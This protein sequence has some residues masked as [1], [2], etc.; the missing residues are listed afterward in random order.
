M[1]VKPGL[2]EKQQRRQQQSPVNTSEGKVQTQNRK[3]SFERREFGL[4]SLDDMRGEDII[5]D[6]HLQVCLLRHMTHVTVKKREQRF[7]R[8]YFQY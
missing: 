1:Q 5:R 8:L 4:R 3:G 7:G 2:F 6:S